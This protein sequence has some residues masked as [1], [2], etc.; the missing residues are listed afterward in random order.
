[1]KQVSNFFPNDVLSELLRS[2]RVHSTIYCHSELTAPWGFRVDARAVASFHLVIEGTCWLEVQDGARPI[3]LTKG[4]LVVLPHGHAHQVRDDLRHPARSL[5]DLIAMHMVADGRPLRYGGSGALTEL[6]CGGFIIEDRDALPILAAL[7]PVLYV[8]SQNSQPHEWLPAVIALLCNEIAAGNP[9]G[10]A[11]V[12]RLMDVLLAQAIRLYQPD[13]DGFRLPSLGILKDPQIASALRL[14]HEDPQCAWTA[15]GL[16]AR[17]AMSRSAFSTRFRLI[18]G[19][20][21][22]RYLTR[23]RLTKAADRL[24]TSGDSLLDIALQTGYASDV[25]LSKA[26][27]RYFGASPGA[28][29]RSVQDVSPSMSATPL[30]HDMA[31]PLRS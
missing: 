6:L 24:R 9:G 15:N 25:A 4:D 28:Y 3:L 26:F 7:P 16:A 21:P 22:M 17:V 20:S 1:M 19:E 31:T 10:E 27:K 5:D 30:A 2:I 18:I 29:R 23:Y 12:T 14:I 13:L 11:V 8:Q